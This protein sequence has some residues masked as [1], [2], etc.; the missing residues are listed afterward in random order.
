MYRLRLFS[1][2]LAAL[3]IT[4]ASDLLANPAEARRAA[5]SIVSGIT[6][7]ECEFS[8]E[9]NWPLF[10]DGD[11]V[12]QVDRLELCP[13][14]RPRMLVA[15]IENVYPDEFASEHYHR[16]GLS[17]TRVFLVDISINPSNR[18]EPG[19]GASL[20]FDC[21]EAKCRLIGMMS[22]P[23]H[24]LTDQTRVLEP[25]QE[26]ILLAA[27][28][29]NAVSSI[30]PIRTY[31][32]EYYY[33]MGQWPESLDQLGL[34][35]V[36]LYSQDIEAVQLGRDGIVQARLS[37]AFG[38]GKFLELL[39]YEEMSGTSMRWRCRSNLPYALLNELRGL[40]CQAVPFATVDTD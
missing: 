10:V 23:L 29:A 16:L 24:R 2:L 33:S 25:D 37:Q 17:G 7:S 15:R 9:V 31:L 6:G 27:R 30:S 34:D 4:P 22:T 21:P 5:V 26:R 40:N 20:V 36:T 3:A 28:L 14:W 32:L 18:S 13:N 12:E 39:P 11:R 38:N 8:G 1:T 35:P 19:E